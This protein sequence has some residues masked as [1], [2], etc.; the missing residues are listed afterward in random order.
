MHENEEAVI[1]SARAF[2]NFS[3]EKRI[4]VLLATRKASEMLV[5]LLDHSSREVVYNVCGVLMNL[6]PEATHKKIFLSGEGVEKYV[7]YFTPN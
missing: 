6:M 2:G 5:M 7:C 4:R 3:R 1:E